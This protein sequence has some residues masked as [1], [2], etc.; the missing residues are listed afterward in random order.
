MVPWI[1]SNKYKADPNAFIF[2][3]DTCQKFV[4]WRNFDY[5]IYDDSSYG[6]TFGN[7]HDLYIA[8]GCKSNTSSYCQ[9]NYSY[10][11]YNSYNLINTGTQSTAFQVADYEVYLVKIN[12]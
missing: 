8:T 4:Q 9:S 12:K 2:S 1:N 7:G 3:L 11:F 6:P 5:A 10:G